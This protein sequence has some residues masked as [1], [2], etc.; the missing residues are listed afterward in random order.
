MPYPDLRI[1][2]LGAGVQSS[3]LALMIEKEEVPAIDAAIFAD[4]QAE[5]KEVYRHLEYLKTQVSYPIYQVSAGNL[6]KDV[7]E[8]TRGLRKSY[9]VPFFTKNPDKPEKRRGILQRQCTQDY[10][11]RPI[12]KH[13]RELLGIKK[14]K[15]VKKD[16]KVELLLGISTDEA[17][18]MK[19]NS[20]KYITNL[21]PL[22]DKKMTREDCISWL[23]KNNYNNPPRSAC[24]FCPYRSAQEWTNLKE[25]HPEEWKE[26]IE[27]DKLIRVPPSSSKVK[28]FLYLHDD[29]VPI[30]EINFSEKL[31][32]NNFNNECE[33]M[34]GI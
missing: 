27:F 31:E 14:Y 1:L 10:K 21:F 18:R 33:G 4:T 3:T 24:T 26:V 2:S 17:A 23:A 12:I 8:A 13:I 19:P 7:I 5:P 20:L 22:I 29:C 30:S 16:T 25:H 11:I 34:C 28:E 9:K 15:N 6:K 32:K